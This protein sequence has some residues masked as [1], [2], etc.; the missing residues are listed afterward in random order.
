MRS[1]RILVVDD[2]PQIR[3]IVTSYLVDEGFEV[4]EAHDG[5]TALLR[6]GSDLDLVILDIGL[7]GIDGIEV[8]R[9]LRS[10]TDVPAI[11]VTARAEET[12]R[13]I[14]LS[15]G[16]DDYVTKPF[17][18]RELVLR[19]KAI[20]RRSS[21]VV[22]RPDGTDEFDGLTIDTGARVVEVDGTELELTALEFDLLIALSDAPGLVLTRHQLIERVWGWDFVGDERVVDV[23]IRNLRKKIGDDAGKPR[24]IT[25]VRGVGYK[26]TASST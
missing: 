18:P 5:E 11:L 14:G 17:S 23:H 1:S 20:L 13:L 26:F 7:P 24:F 16:A 9:E 15:V 25:T 3:R 2:E 19:V 12:D 8:L 21:Q 22:E 4:V 6:A 10:R